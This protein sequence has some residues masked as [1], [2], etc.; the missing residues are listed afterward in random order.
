MSRACPAARRDLMAKG[1][2]LHMTSTR[3]WRAATAG[4]AAAALVLAGCAESERS[5]EGGNEGSGGG[6]FVFAGAA[7]P[8]LLDPA[9]ASDG[10]TFR[11]AR[12]I[13]EGLVGTEP[14]TPD[15][16]PLL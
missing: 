9:F 15:P 11:V 12:Q 5:D 6:T 4:L 8:K 14:G 2:E 16:A 1:D 7:E 3:R 13:F 10:E